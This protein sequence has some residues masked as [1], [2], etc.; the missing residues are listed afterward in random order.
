MGMKT[1]SIFQRS[2][3]FYRNDGAEIHRRIDFPLWVRLEFLLH[4]H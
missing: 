4:D 1:E 3:G 2:I